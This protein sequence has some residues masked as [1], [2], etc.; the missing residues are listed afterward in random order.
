M[1]NYKEIQGFPIQ[2]LSSDPVPFAQAKENNPYVRTWSS[3]GSLNTGRSSIA[4]SSGGTQTASLAFGG[5]APGGVTTANE[6]YNGTSWTEL[7]DLNQARAG[8]AGVG[9]TTAAAAATG[10]NRGS[11][12][13]NVYYTQHEQWD[14]SSW[15]ETTELNVGRSFVFSLGTAPAFNAAVNEPKLAIDL[16]ERFTEVPEAQ[17]PA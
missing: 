2:N 13:P 3:G 10:D 8:L 1:A 11:P 9:T 5:E 15:T 14:G 7:N 4:G 12:P 16:T 6:Q 17:A